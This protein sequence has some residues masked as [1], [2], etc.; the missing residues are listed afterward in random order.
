MFIHIAW[1]D[2]KCKVLVA[3]YKAA[4]GAA[5]AA[6]TGE[7][8][9]QPRGAG[10]NQVQSDRLDQTTCAYEPLRV[11]RLRTRQFGDERDL[12]WKQA[13]Q[14]HQV[15]ICNLKEYI[16]QSQPIEAFSRNETIN[17][18][19]A[20]GLTI[21]SSSLM[22]GLGLRAGQTL[23]TALAVGESEV[24]GSAP[25]A[26]FSSQEPLL[27]KSLRKASGTRKIPRLRL[28]NGRPVGRA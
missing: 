27:A 11:A 14:T 12:T 4:G 5:E 7:L 21:I 26:D 10:K 9:P 23:L 3:C 18:N 13:L 17:A 24:R 22:E 1:V 25:Q 20:K 19:V 15:C 2:L 28:G 6:R 16:I 8:N